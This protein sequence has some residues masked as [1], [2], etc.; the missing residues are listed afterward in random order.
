MCACLADL[1]AYR[2]DDLRLL[3]VVFRDDEV[4]FRLQ[5]R[6]LCLVCAGLGV[7]ALELGYAALVG[8]LHALPVSH[9]ASGLGLGSLQVG[10]ALVGDGAVALVVE[11]VQ[12]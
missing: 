5:D 6:G 4:G 12:H 10:L 2:R 9:G 7:V 3:Q 11:D 1:S 8:R